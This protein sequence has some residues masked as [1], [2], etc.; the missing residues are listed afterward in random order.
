MIEVL[1]AEL[2]ALADLRELAR[3]YCAVELTIA[4]CGCHTVS[5]F[6]DGIKIV[7]EDKDLSACVEAVKERITNL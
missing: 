3:Q 2:S 6:V 7:E 5:L 4:D 1:P